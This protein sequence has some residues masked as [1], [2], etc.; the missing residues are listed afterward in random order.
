[1]SLA[2]GGRSGRAAAES[3]PGATPELAPELVE[4]AGLHG[5]LLSYV[6]ALDTERTASVEAV[7]AVLRALD[8]PVGR[9]EDAGEAIRARQRALAERIV[10][11]VIVAWDGEAT[12]TEI[13]LPRDAASGWVDCRLA[14]GGHEVQSWKRSLDRLPT[15]G[16]RLAAGDAYVVKRLPTPGALPMGYHRLE[17]AVAGQRRT[18]TLI[19]APRRAWS[20][21]AEDGGGEGEEGERRW[22]VF[23]PL[24]ALHTRQSWGC[25]DFTDLAALA[26]WS[27]GLG[28]SV[29]ATL[30][31]LAAFLDEPCDPSPY[32]PASRLFW[33]EL[34]VDPR[35]LPELGRSLRAQ[36]LISSS[37]F[38]AEVAAL[39]GRR[40]VDY[41]RL[42]ALKRPILAALAE[43]FFAEA[44]GTGEARRA[45]FAA[46]RDRHPRLDDYAAFRAVGDRRRETWQSWPERLRSGRLEP[47][48][49]DEADSSDSSLRPVGGG[50]AGG[51]GRGGAP[52]TAAVPAS[53]SICRWGS[54][55]RP[56]TSGASASC[57]C[58]GWPPARPPTSC[59]SRGQDWGFRPHHPDRLREDGYR[60]YA[61]AIAH[62]LEH[63]GALR[64]D[65][66]MQL[67]RLFFVPQG[68][69]ATE[70]LYVQYPADELYAVLS[71][72]SHR[73][74]AR[75]VG[76]NLGTVPDAVN[77]AL[78]EHGISTLFILQFEADA[79]LGRG[80]LHR[81]VGE[82]EVAGFNSHDMPTFRGFLDG[83][84]VEDRFGLG[85]IAVPRRI[86]SWSSGPGSATPSPAGWPRA[87]TSPATP[88]P[89]TPELVAAALA[90]LGASASPLVVVNLEDL[91]GERS[92][93]N[94]P[95]TTVERPN[96]RRRA[97]R[98][99]EAM[100]ADPGVVAALEGLDA[101]RRAPRA[102]GGGSAEPDAE[103]AGEGRRQWESPAE[104][105]SLRAMLWTSRWPPSA[106]R[107]ANC[108]ATLGPPPRRRRARSPTTT[109]TSST[110]GATSTS[111]TSSGRGRCGWAI[112][113]AST[114][115]CGR[116]TPPGLPSSAISTIGTAGRHPLAAR[117]ASGVWE[118]F[119]AEAGVGS[120]YK[121]HL[122]S[123]IDDYRVDKADP[124]A[125]HAETPPATASI[126][127]DLAY[128]WGDA[129]WMARRGEH[130]A[131]D[132]P[133]A[134]YEVHLGSWRRPPEEGDRLLS[135]RELAPLLADHVKRT[136][137]THV[138]LMPV[139]E[140]PFYGSW[141]YQT[142]GYFAATSR[143]G[144]PQDL[145]ALI[146]HL[147]REG[148]G[149]I[150][151]WVPSHFPTDEYGLGFFDGTHLYEHG[152]PREGFHPDWSSFIFN[153]GRHEVRS[154]LISSALFWL[155]VFHADGLRVDAVAS[156]LYRDYSRPA[157]EWVPNVHGGRE[158]LEA[159]E[160]IRQLNAEIARRVPAVRTFAEES[161]S[162]PGVSHPT[163]AGGLGF[164]YK[165][166][167]GWMHDTL[168]YLAQDPLHRK[169][170][171][172]KLT[173]RAMYAFAENYLLPL[174]HD[175]VVHGKRSLV[176]KM[177]GDDWQ[178]FANVR[179]LFGYQWA[180]PG[181]KLLFMGG[182]L[183]QRREWDHDRGLD[184]Q[185]VER[186][187]G[188][189]SGLL[190]WVGDLNRLYRDR[191]ALHQLDCEP[192]GLRLA[193][194]RRRRSQ[195]PRLPAPGSR[196]R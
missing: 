97:R 172:D 90:E 20:A 35:R 151:D 110:R 17:L 72:E 106:G 138:E 78:A 93:Q 62:H 76:E 9:P 83:A 149:V 191:P 2:D 164:A 82:A 19:S 173:F 122:E 85:L 166:D 6:D 116:R 113:T 136:G 144:T 12:T 174:S 185:P 50:R 55:R 88:R 66:V 186:E 41:R 16:E 73:A 92:P 114:S 124:F 157:G 159:I 63:A 155:E 81:P 34:Y 188:P 125:V 137:F 71:L 33:N 153:Y 181:K 129:G 190:R 56:T 44:V 84:D 183:G 182:E 163:A 196:P 147:H 103:P 133:V 160:F 176:D 32:T 95:G 49:Y 180:Q 1:M 77:A 152:D 8:A 148:I 64:I 45:A 36:A 4:L 100:A 139:M 14:I 96:W 108:R 28:G 146:D 22:G 134:V 24:Y 11:P 117:G 150:L 143:Y 70:G 37:D 120:R 194:P 130:A 60:Y 105:P 10:E 189:A 15:V 154:F 40:L 27:A 193:R 161:T 46:F 101:A 195:P 145:M 98:S 47:G 126:V 158:N 86:A 178:R 52:L 29:V 179:L 87:A 99:L 192:A 109:F 169:H 13:V 162:Y 119:V 118:G 75:L 54:T 165:W 53:F 57:S 107:P 23:L 94:V 104:M 168:D 65:H 135:Y 187:A 123:R 21:A 127:W 112:T 171:H 141:G 167:M 91:W 115:P 69:A 175:E 102:P 30:P 170:A 42:Y 39:R 58:R 18:A 177:P 61:A 25:G 156:M 131:R 5:L 80:V 38:A 7:M 140:H 128:E 3:V 59:F 111:A 48:D 68:M 79:D 43:T 184:W 67:H 142:V 26:R 132:R 121:Y 31:L 51:G 89:T 74:R